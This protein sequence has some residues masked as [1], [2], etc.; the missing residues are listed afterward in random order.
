MSNI[1]IGILLNSGLGNQL[2]MIFALLSYSIDYLH[3]YVLFF[4]PATMKSYWDSILYTLKSFAT[5]INDK[6]NTINIYEEPFF[7]YSKIPIVSCDTNMK[8][9][10]QSY[11]YFDHNLQQIMSILNLNSQISSVRDEYLHYFSKKTIALHFRIG[12]Y[13]GLQG[14]HCIKKPEYYI[15]A[16]EKLNNKL[17]EQND[18]IYNY[19]ILY[20]CQKQ[21]NDIVSIYLDVLNK[22]FNTSNKS[23]QSFGNQLNF[24]LLQPQY[25][26]HVKK[27]LGLIG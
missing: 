22:K 18:N 2:F 8:G 9:Y 19:D 26:L 6:T 3:D 5:E 16:F 15:G 12:D 17:Q 27:T 4:D 21:D 20:F 23:N 13:I 11:K 1:K 7:H 25:I 24:D 14:F 10:F